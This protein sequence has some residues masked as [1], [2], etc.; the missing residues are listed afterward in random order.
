VAGTLAVEIPAVG[1]PAAETQVVEIL[2][3]ATRS[4]W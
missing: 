3:V 1:I 2:A 4:P